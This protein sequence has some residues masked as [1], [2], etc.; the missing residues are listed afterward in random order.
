MSILDTLQSSTFQASGRNIVSAVL[1]AAGMLGALTLAQQHDL[2][3][4]WGDI[5]TGL[6]QTAKGV[7]VFGGILGPIVLALWARYTAQPAQQKASVAALPNTAVVTTKPTGSASADAAQTASV[8]AKIA[9]LNEVKNV[10]STPEVAAA[11]VSDKVVSGTN[12][13]PATS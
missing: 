9:T 11:T 1:G 5:Q 2:I 7:A 6:A 13:A 8:A 10:I 4:A 12:T 3:Q